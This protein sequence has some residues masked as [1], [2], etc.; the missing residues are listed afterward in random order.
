MAPKA[1]VEVGDGEVVPDSKTSGSHAT[2]VVLPPKKK[3]SAS[4]D[5]VLL[6]IFIVT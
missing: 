1:Q 3:I 4:E 5:V 6:H 2:T